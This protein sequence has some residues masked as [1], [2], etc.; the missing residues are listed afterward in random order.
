[1]SRVLLLTDAAM[2]RHDPP[3]HPE[4]PA[5][6]AAVAAGVADGAATTGASL[7]RRT[8]PPAEPAAIERIHARSYVAA[9]DEAATAGG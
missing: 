3:E 5:R 2:E 6:L 7:E 8:P 4:R 9:L 1:M